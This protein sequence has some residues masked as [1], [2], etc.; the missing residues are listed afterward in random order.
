MS[1]MLRGPVLVLAIWLTVMSVASA[2]LIA[3]KSGEQHQGTIANRD[4][5]RANLAGQEQLAI[6]LDDS[7]ELLRIPI[8]EIEYV[9]FVDGESREVRDLASPEIVEIPAPA[10]TPTPKPTPRVFPNASDPPSGIGFIAAG[11]AVAGLGTFVKFGGSKATVTESSVDVD[12]KSYNAANYVLM[13]GG[14]AL[15]IVGI[16]MQASNSGGGGQYSMI[17]LDPC[18]SPVSGDAA[19]AL[20][21]MF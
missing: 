16:A 8:A 17:S 3:L 4:G 2:D 11:A 10:P 7:A 20:R 9:V 1:E 21:V 13:A 12:E 5:V 14:G 18:L 6:L 19:V 15:M